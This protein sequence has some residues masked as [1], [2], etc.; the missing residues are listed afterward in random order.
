[1][2]ILYGRKTS[3]NVQK[4]VWMLGE[5]KLEFEWI[6]KDGGVGSIDT[7]EYRKIN[8]WAIVPTLDDDGVM[9]RQSNAIVRYLARTY[10]DGE[11]WPGDPAI[12]ADAD[13]WMDWQATEVWS[14]MTPV[15]WGLIRTPADQRDNDLIKRSVDLMHKEFSL[16]NSHLAEKSYVTGSDF[17]MGDFPLGAAT[18]RY[19]SLPIER[20]SLT[21]L[22]AYYARLQERDAYRE[23]V[24][25]PLS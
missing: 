4:S 1:M 6:D 7:P 2:R 11:L 8:P 14:K 9:I 22:E 16:M 19:F 15:F 24:M 18:Y 23:F 25:V 3:I 10:S 5:L 17:T 12:L 20:P 13:R 21:N